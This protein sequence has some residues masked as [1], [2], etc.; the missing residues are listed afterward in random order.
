MAASYLLFSLSQASPPL[1]TCSSW[2]TR[3]AQSPLKPESHTG[4]VR[5]C[6]LVT[7]FP[8]SITYRLL[9][10][11]SHRPSV[12]TPT[13]ISYDIIW[14]S[15]YWGQRVFFH[16]PAPFSV[17]CL[18]L[19]ALADVPS[20]KNMSYLREQL[21]EWD[22]FFPCHFLLILWGVQ[23]DMFLWSFPTL[24]KC[25]S[26]FGLLGKGDD[27]V[28]VFQT[29]CK[30]LKCNHMMFWMPFFTVHNQLIQLMKKRMRNCVH[31][32]DVSLTFCLFFN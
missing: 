7:A 5:I 4:S 18:L 17:L 28:E 20:Q 3:A 23:A 21:L 9:V 32:C 16:F 27:E 6:Y 26:Q 8:S 31:I 14:Y 30:L 19:C 22:K 12:N 24:Q 15:Q 2:R 25:R 13:N 11:N 29:W 1:I 10:A